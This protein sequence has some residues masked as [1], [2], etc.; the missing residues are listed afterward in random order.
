M[1]PTIRDATDADLDRIN[2]IYNEYIVDRHT[3]FDEAPWTIAE[4]R[5]W[6]DAYNDSLGRYHVLVLETEGSVAGFASSSPFRKKAAY[7]SS[8]ETTIVLGGGFVGRGLGEQLFV[9]L[10]D[11]VAA[12]P[13]HRAYALIAL[14]NEPSIV[15]HRK[16]GYHDVGVMDEV[17]FKLG[18]YHSVLMMER[19]F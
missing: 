3:S 1:N 5:S 19:N 8:V 7:A 2:Q 4:R 17:G 16:L 11:R 12:A 13:V 15:L 6:F 18:G 9:A 10:L 14:P